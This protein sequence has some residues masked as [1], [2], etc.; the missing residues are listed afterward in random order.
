[1][2]KINKLIFGFLLVS[3]P[4]LADL[5]GAGDAAIL[6]QLVTQTKKIVEQI[7]QAKDALN[8][9]KYMQEI[10]QL[11]QV[12]E[13]S[14]TGSQFGAL[15]SNVDAIGNE[16]S[17]W[18]SDPFGLKSIKSEISTLQAGIESAERSGDFEK[19]KKYSK[20]LK[21]LKNIQ[22]LGEANAKNQEAIGKGANELDLNRINAESSLIMTTLLQNKEQREVEEEL[23]R[24][25]KDEI[26][27]DFY[28]K[29]LSYSGGKG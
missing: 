23:N 13:L 3:Q 22:F 9:S 18:E 21:N 1:M 6:S 17:D 19:A 2:I 10:E 26:T 4:V 12:K 7:G 16:A 24:V 11:K 28:T 14:D 5:T 25:K 29:G 27:E 8:I 15:F 20:V